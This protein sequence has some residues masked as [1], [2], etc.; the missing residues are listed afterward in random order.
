MYVNL[1]LI[2]IAEETPFL[3]FVEQSCLTASG[4]LQQQ[5]LSLSF[6]KMGKEA[7]TYITACLNGTS[8]MFKVIF[9]VLMEFYLYKKT[10]NKPKPNNLSKSRGF[11]I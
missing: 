3:K 4:S 9:S 8:N 7:K 5:G 10:Q 6:S 2:L 1:H 11:S